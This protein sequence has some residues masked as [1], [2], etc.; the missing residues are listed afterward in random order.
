MNKKL[1]GVVLVTGAAAAVVMATRSLWAPAV[2][3]GIQEVLIWTLDDSE[4]DD[5]QET[6]E[7]TAFKAYERG[8][9]N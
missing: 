6:E 1:V 2:K 4:D 5:E 7:V 9:I 3:A 8:E